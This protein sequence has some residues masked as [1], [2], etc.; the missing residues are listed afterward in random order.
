MI[1]VGMIN[2]FNIITER[3]TIEEIG[4]SDINIFAHFPNEDIEIENIE[5]MVEYFQSCEL[6]ENCIELLEYIHDNYDE[7]GMRIT[8]DCECPQ[9]IILGYRN[10]IHCGHCNKRLSN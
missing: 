1:H 4:L 2:S 5:L 7:H 10:K 6:F 3:N 8:N 9:P